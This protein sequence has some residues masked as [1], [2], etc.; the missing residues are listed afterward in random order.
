[1][2]ILVMVMTDECFGVWDFSLSFDNDSCEQ[3]KDLQIRKEK[4]D[5]QPKTINALALYNII[6]KYNL[7]VDI[8]TIK[9]INV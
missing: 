6:L 4:I 2:E 3:D 5:F 9:G 8:V 1:M 7:L